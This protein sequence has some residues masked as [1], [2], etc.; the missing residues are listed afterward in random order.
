MD[1]SP[2]TKK[3]LRTPEESVSNPR[4]AL[5]ASLARFPGTDR[6]EYREHDE[7]ENLAEAAHRTRRPRG[8]SNAR[9]RSRHRTRA[10]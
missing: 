6:A 8:R 4:S 3:I 9:R 7:K 5:I 2:G 1:K 10:C